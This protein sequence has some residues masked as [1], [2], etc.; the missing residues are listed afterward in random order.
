MRSIH[1]D[2]RQRQGQAW[3]DTATTGRRCA[4]SCNMERERGSAS[5]PLSVS[6]VGCTRTVHS[7]IAV[8]CP[9]PH[10][11]PIIPASLPGCSLF[12]PGVLDDD[13]WFHLP[14]CHPWYLLR[15]TIVYRLQGIR[16]WVS[17]GREKPP[18]GPSRLSC[19]PMPQALL[20]ASPLSAAAAD[21]RKVS[22]SPRKAPGPLCSG[23]CCMGERE[24]EGT[25]VGMRWARRTCRQPD[26]G[27]ATFW[28]GWWRATQVSGL[29]DAQ[30]HVRLRWRRDMKQRCLPIGS[31]E[32][33]GRLAYPHGY[34]DV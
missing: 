10:P 30:K 13:P 3:V 8:R 14:P 21:L 7:T 6:A 12:R 11:P 23:A 15:T 31:Q 29:G 20:C 32:P 19:S 26:G 17:S 25:E 24:R 9:F 1:T 18:S 27:K 5:F 4:K 33:A 2:R 22:C 28:D 16:W 34:V